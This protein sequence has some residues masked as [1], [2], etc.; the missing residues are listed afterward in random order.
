LY[1]IFGSAYLNYASIYLIIWDT[2]VRFPG[3]KLP[4]ND[5]V[6]IIL[7]YG[8]MATLL[9]TMI[10]FVKKSYYRTQDTIVLKSAKKNYVLKTEEIYF[11]ESMDDYV[12]VH[13]LNEVLTC[14]QRLSNFE[15]MLDERQFVRIH[16]A[17]IINK[18]HIDSYTQSYVELRGKKLPIGR[19][20][21]NGLELC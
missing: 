19:S 17:F 16:R 9:A 14:Y 21:K 11:I 15:K 12:K 4:G 2:S 13:T 18:K 20:Y 5:D 8:Y 6:L 7:L 1:I 10:H 3:S